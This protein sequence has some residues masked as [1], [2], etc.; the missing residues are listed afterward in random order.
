MEIAPDARSH[1]IRWC[2]GTL[3]NFT[4]G[5]ST[6][7]VESLC[8]EKLKHERGHLCHIGLPP[9]GLQKLRFIQR[10]YGQP[11]HCPLKVL[12]DFK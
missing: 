2:Y 8:K 10:A 1:Q 6:C 12:A 4:I 7:E 11:F 9:S 3:S 5:Q